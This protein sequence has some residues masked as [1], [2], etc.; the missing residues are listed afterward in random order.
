[1]KIKNIW[2]HHQDDLHGSIQVFEKKIESTGRKRLFVFIFFSDVR[3]GEKKQDVDIF[4]KKNG[5]IMCKK[6]HGD[7][8][9]K[10][11]HQLNSSAT[12]VDDWNPTPVDMSEIPSNLEL[13]FW[14][15]KRSQSKPVQ[16][17]GCKLDDVDHVIF[18]YN[19][20]SITYQSTLKFAA[21]NSFKPWIFLHGKKMIFKKTR[22][23]HK[24][25]ASQLHPLFLISLN[26]LVLSSWI[27]FYKFVS[28]PRIDYLKSSRDCTG[29][30]AFFGGSVKSPDVTAVISNHHLLIFIHLFFGE[31]LNLENLGI[32]IKAYGWWQPEIRRLLT[33]WGW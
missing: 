26:V 10:K 3:D 17:W 21:C 33:S 12:P 5:G 15:S 22:Q 14:S 27:F 4:S 6:K 2:N 30:S 20:G 9:S 24:L 28:S 18:G 19:E 32:Q 8:S 25:W 1:M 16:D 7:R 13:L 11:S 29:V 31:S 23:E